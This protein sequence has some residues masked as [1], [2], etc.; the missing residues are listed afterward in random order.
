MVEWT[1]GGSLFPKEEPMDAD[2]IDWAIEALT[3]GEQRGPADQRIEEDGGKCQRWN[4]KWDHRDT[5]ELD[6]VEN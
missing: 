1:A 5:S 3:H 6:Q 2:D 4:E